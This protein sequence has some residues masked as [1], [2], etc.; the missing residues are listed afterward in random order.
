MACLFVVLVGV[1]LLKGDWYEKIFDHKK[2]KPLAELLL[3]YDSITTP[4]LHE[5]EH[6]YAA[7]IKKEDPTSKHVL[8]LPGT[9]TS[10]L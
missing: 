6:T 8:E 3:H 4:Q 5:I 9:R 10:E 1:L 2:V 7:N